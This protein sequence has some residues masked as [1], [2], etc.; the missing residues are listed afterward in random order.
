QLIEAFLRRNEKVHLV[1]SS[2]GGF[3]CLYLANKYDLKAVLINPAV[4][5]HDTLMKYQGVEFAKSYYDG[6]RFEFTLSHTKSLL[7]YQSNTIKNPKNI[8]TLLQKDDETLDYKEAELL[9]KDT[10]LI[11]EEGGSHSF[12]GI[13]RYFDFFSLYNTKKVVFLYF[14]L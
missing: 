4:Y 10:N 9:L 13:E 8:M 1:G 11:V 5:A 14:Y 2:L 7:D 3:Y 6:S 12:D